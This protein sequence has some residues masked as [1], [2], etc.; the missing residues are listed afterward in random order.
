MNTRHTILMMLTACLL[1]ACSSDDDFNNVDDSLARIIDQQSLEIDQT[2]LQGGWVEEEFTYTDEYGNI[3]SKKGSSNQLQSINIVDKNTLVQYVTHNFMGQEK[4]VKFALTYHYDPIQRLFYFDNKYVTLGVKY[5]I[6]YLSDEY[7]VLQRRTPYDTL[8]KY[9]LKR[10][11]DAQVQEWETAYKPEYR[12]NI[13]DYGIHRG[14]D[15]EWLLDDASQSISKEDFRELM[16]GHPLKWVESHRIHDDGRIEE[17]DFFYLLCGA[18]PS[19]YLY[20]D[21]SM[22]VID[23]TD[24]DPMH[25]FVLTEYPY[26]YDAA[27]NRVTGPHPHMTLLSYDAETDCVLVVERRFNLLTV[28]QRTTMEWWAE[29]EA[30]VK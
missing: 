4:R 5:Y 3:A 27:S 6:N 7:M 28:Y 11:S 8:E 2:L 24:A 12:G 30:R 17:V 9:V 29:Q 22:K 21:T 10:V 13:A 15:G 19:S 20:G 23:S 1:A 18:G 25:P 16:V 14:D 26:E